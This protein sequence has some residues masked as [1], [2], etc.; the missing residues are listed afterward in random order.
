MPAGEVVVKVNYEL[1]G[2]WHTELDLPASELPR[3]GDSVHF[4]SYERSSYRVHEVVWFLN[5]VGETLSVRVVL[6]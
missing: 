1:P 5:S 6:R 4:A 3:K 2:V